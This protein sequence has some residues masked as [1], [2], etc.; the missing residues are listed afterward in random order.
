MRAMPD[1]A[2]PCL[3]RSSA[4]LRGGWSRLGPCLLGWVLVAALLLAVLR[5]PLQRVRREVLVERCLD[6]LDDALVERSKSAGGYPDEPFLSGGELAAL[7]VAGGWLAE[8]PA[9]PDTGLPFGSVDLE[10]DLVFYDAP[11]GGD[12]YRLEVLDVA[13]ERVVASRRGE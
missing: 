7:L 11:P 6:A 3:T 13:G 4:S 9:N 1:R 5:E 2:E 8:L 12:A 10:P